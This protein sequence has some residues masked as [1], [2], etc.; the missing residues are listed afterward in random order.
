MTLPEF[1]KHREYV[2]QQ[3]A[4]E[5]AAHKDHISSISHDKKR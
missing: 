1:I 3:E 5:D 4:L 2:T